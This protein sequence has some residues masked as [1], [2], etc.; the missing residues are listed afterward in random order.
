LAHS[1]LPYG[2]HRSA[3]LRASVAVSVAVRGSLYKGNVCRYSTKQP[4]SGCGAAVGR[5]GCAHR[6]VLA[7]GKARVWPCPQRGSVVVLRMSDRRQRRPPRLSSSGCCRREAGCGPTPR[8]CLQQL[9][10]ARVCRLEAARAVGRPDERFRS[11]RPGRPRSGDNHGW[12]GTA[13]CPK[14]RMA[15]ATART[16]TRKLRSSARLTTHSLRPAYRRRQAG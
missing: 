14:P 10:V 16:D 7:G 11:E 15:G 8:P 9:L 5:A 4:S 13:A 6:R 1:M 2:V 12:V 3:P